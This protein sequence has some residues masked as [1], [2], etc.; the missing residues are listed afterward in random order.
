MGKTGIVGLA[1]AV[2]LAFSAMDVLAEEPKQENK[3]LGT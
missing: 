2:S 1:L 3:L